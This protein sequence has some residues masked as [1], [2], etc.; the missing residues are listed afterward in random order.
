MDTPTAQN[1][2]L[3]KKLMFW[4]GAFV[5]VGFIARSVDPIF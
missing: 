4:G 5:S 3:G 2:T 1:L